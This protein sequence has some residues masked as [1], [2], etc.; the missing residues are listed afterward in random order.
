M[1]ARL[2]VIL[3]GALLSVAACAQEQK[4]ATA[5]APVA[6]E[7]GKNY[8]LIEPPQPTSSGDKIEVLEVFSYACVHCAHFQPYADEIKSKLTEAQ[9]MTA[10]YLYDRG[11]YLMP[12][13]VGT[14][15]TKKPEPVL[16]D[17]Q[18]QDVSGILTSL[19]NGSMAEVAQGA[20]KTAARAGNQGNLPIQ[21]NCHRKL[22]LQCVSPAHP[23]GNRTFR[24]GASTRKAGRREEA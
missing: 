24:R 20:A 13:E 16:T 3:L 5:S 19:Q 17:D 7:A 6:A 15:R 2:P 18:W 1:F 21:S 10:T 22:F 12:N 14:N 23:K 4:D 8:F 9:T 11:G